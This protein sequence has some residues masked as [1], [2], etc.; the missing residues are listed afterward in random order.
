MASTRDTETPDLKIIDGGMTPD[1]LTGKQQGFCDG[2][3]R[4][5]SQSAAYRLAYDAENMADT[6]VWTEASKLFAHPAVSQRLKA[7]QARQSDAA[8]LSGLA[9]RQ[10]IQRTLHGLTTGGEND[11]AK[12]RACELLGKLSDVAAFTERV[13]V[14]DDSRT[15]EE[16]TVELEETL[17]KAFS[18]SA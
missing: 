9:T 15:A 13:V 12:L 16:I 6:S 1:K 8:L 4:G 10:H 7:L 18:Q 14:N 17:R 2:I 5:L 11:A 3:L